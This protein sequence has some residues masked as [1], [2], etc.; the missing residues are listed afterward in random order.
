MLEVGLSFE[1]GVYY[2]EL[3]EATES[4]QFR[5]LMFVQLNFIILA[6]VVI[7]KQRLEVIDQVLSHVSKMSLTMAVSSA[8]PI[9]FSF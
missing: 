8:F 4:C 2:F 5:T 6:I 9:V 3:V 7:S 1:P